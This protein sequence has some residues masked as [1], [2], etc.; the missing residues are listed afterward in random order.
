MGLGIKTFSVRPYRE[1]G[2]RRLNISYLFDRL[3][4]VMEEIFIY[5]TVTFNDS[6]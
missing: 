1:K 3:V 5:F 4:T 6:F 2:E